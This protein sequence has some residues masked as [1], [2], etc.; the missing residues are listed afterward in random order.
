MLVLPQN[1]TYNLNYPV[2]LGDLRR[3]S[4]TSMRNSKLQADEDA[5]HRG[6]V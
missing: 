1:A 2:G 4:S 3:S 5:P 6:G